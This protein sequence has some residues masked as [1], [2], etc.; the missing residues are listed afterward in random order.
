MEETAWTVWEQE[1]AKAKPSKKVSHRDHCVSGP[2][3]VLQH[4][5]QGSMEAPE[6]MAGAPPM[7][8][9]NRGSRLLPELTC[10]LE[11]E[12]TCSSDSGGL[13]GA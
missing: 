12:E 3:N 8:N 10:L 11:E 2:P 7:V 13:E 4:R 5:A 6:G 9:E 1:K